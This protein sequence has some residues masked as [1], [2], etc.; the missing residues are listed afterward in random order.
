MFGEGWSGKDLWKS[1][2]YKQHLS[3]YKRI[4]TRLPAREHRE[5]RDHV[6]RPRLGPS[7]TWRNQEWRQRWCGQRCGGAPGRAGHGSGEKR[8]SGGVVC[9]DAKRGPREVRRKSSA[10]CSTWG[11]GWSLVWCPGRVQEGWLTQARFFIFYFVIGLRDTRAFPC[12]LTFPPSTQS[13][14]VCDPWDTASSSFP[15]THCL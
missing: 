4:W 9:V 14:E 10:V 6:W 8:D 3:D 13:L 12:S 11:V 1:L 7:N 15:L 5:W 2:G